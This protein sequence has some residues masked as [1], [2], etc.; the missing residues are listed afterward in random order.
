ME[1]TPTS[2]HLEATH[3]LKLHLLEWSQEGV[4]L[5][6]LHG[7]GNEAHIWDDFAPVVAAHYRTV[8][9][10]HRGH[11]KSDWDPEL[12]YDH[13]F[14]V[15]DVEAV[16]EALGMERLVIIGHSLG[17]RVATLFAGRHPERLAGLVLVQGLLLSRRT[18]S[19]LPGLARRMRLAGL[20]ER[21]AA[22]AT[23]WQ[24]YRRSP[25]WLLA[26][27]GFSLGVQFLRI[28]THIVVA[29]GLGMPLASEQALQLFVLIPLL[30]ISLTLPITINGI[31]LRE[32]VSA[33]LLV[34]A[35]LTAAAA[36]A[37]E[38]VAYVVTVAFSL[39]GGLLFWVG[40]RVGEGSARAGQP[41]R[42]SARN[43][44]QLGG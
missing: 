42:G 31:G 28:L 24:V 12:R 17:G 38:V 44:G 3:G 34:D 18:G 2:R 20:E 37:V 25:R 33:T 39:Y 36:V 9:L 23:E 10:D 29:A 16:T 41:T 11:G 19:R 21:L 43:G 15:D 7:F 30:G 8:A 1:A 6:L 32:S 14:M 4:P 35:G 26:V 5:L 40:R 27:G 22:L 13:D